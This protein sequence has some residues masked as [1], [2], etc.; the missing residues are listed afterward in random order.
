MSEQERVRMYNERRAIGGAG[1]L[2]AYSDLLVDKSA[3]DT[4]AQFVRQ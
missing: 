1:F 3:N 2:G 4:A